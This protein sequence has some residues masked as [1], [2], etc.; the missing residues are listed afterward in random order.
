MAY[1]HVLL[2]I[3]AADA[4]YEKIFS[5]LS[6][7]ELKA[8]FVKQYRKG[9]DVLVDGR[10]IRASQIN[11]VLIVKTNDTDETT[12]ERINNDSLDRISKMNRESDSI[13]F[14]SPGS[15]VESSSKCTTESKG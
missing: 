15:G 4:G 12:R 7:A 11:S 13:V 8:M 10:V 2:K 5:D 1:F 9:K 6:E 3:D 14:I